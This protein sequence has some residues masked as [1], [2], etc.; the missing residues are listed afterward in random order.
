[1]TVI[2]LMA[3]LATFPP[4]LEVRGAWEGISCPVS[5]VYRKT[6]KWDLVDRDVVLLDV[7]QES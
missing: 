4:D 2:E 3:T 1:M 7:D 5:D 6:I